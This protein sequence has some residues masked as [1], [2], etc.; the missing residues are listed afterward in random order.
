MQLYIASLIVTLVSLSKTAKGA[1]SRPI[2]NARLVAYPSGRVF[3]ASTLLPGN[4]EVANGEEVI[5]LCNAYGIKV[6]EPKRTLTVAEA[7]ALAPKATE[8]KAVTIDPGK[9][10]AIRII[11]RNR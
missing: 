11:K 6:E 3:L 8:P 10:R 9:T 5:A 4:V 2:G 7:L 1:E